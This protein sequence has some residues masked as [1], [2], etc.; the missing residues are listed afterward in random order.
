M[1][2]WTYNQ[3]G[4]TYNSVGI[5][6]NFLADFFKPYYTGFIHTTKALLRRGLGF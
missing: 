3:V 1:A 2:Q 4:I 5:K 6:Y